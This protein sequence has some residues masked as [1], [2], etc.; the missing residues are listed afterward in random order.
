[1]CCH[2]EV[3]E[4][5]EIISSFP[6]TDVVII[7]VKDKTCSFTVD[8]TKTTAT[9]IAQKLSA[10]GFKSFV[11][12][13]ETIVSDQC[14]DSCST[15]PST[16][17]S[18]ADE[19]GMKAT[20]FAAP[21]LCCIKEEKI[22]TAA[23][24]SLKGIFDID[25]DIPSKTFTVEFTAPATAKQIRDV[26]G[27]QLK[28]VAWVSGDKV[29]EG[30]G[31]CG[32]GGPGHSHGS[33][34]AKSVPIP[35][36]I[37][38]AD[39]LHVYDIHGAL[40]SFVS[41]VPL[42]TLCFESHSLPGDMMTPCFDAEGRSGEADE[43]CMC[44][45]E[46]PHIHAHVKASG[47]GSYN[48]SKLTAV[49]LTLVEGSGSASLPV[50]DALPEDC[51]HESSALIS[52]PEKLSIRV[53]HG[54]HFDD[55]VLHSA[56]TL[57]LRNSHA[58]HGDY[59]GALVKCA[60]RSDVLEFYKIGDEKFNILKYINKKLPS[61]SGYSDPRVMA[62]LNVVP[63]KKAAHTGCCGGGHGNSHEHGHSH[64][65]GADEP[66]SDSDEDADAKNPAST[67]GKSA[68]HVTN[69]CCASEI[70]PIRAIVEPLPGV[71][72]VSFN[73]TS[74]IVYVEHDYSITPLAKI[75]GELNKARFGASV[76]KDA[77]APKLQLNASSEGKSTV[78]V[79]HICCASEIP[80]I[81][82]IVEPLPGVKKVS[83]NVTSKLVYVDH[84]FNVTPVATILEELNKARFGAT[85]R[86]D[87]GAN[88]ASSTATIAPPSVPE[89]THIGGLRWNVVASGILWVVSMFHAAYAPLKYVAIGS[90][91]I[92]IFHIALKCFESLK[93]YTIDSN[94]LM[95]VA[96]VGAMGLQDYPEAAGLTFLFSLGEWLES[97]ATGK[98]RKAL[99]SI[100]NL[101]PETANK[102]ITGPDGA[103]RYKAM[104]AE[105]I[106]IG[107]YV[108]VKS[109]DK[110]P[111]DGTVFKGESVI[112][113]SSLTGES[114]P[115]T[116]KAEDGVYSG[117]INI[118]SS[119]LTVLVTATTENS[120]VAK[121]IELVEEAQ[122]NRSPTEKLVDE[123]AKRYTPIVIV[124]SI[125]MCTI[126]WAFSR[127][128]GVEWT[129]RGVT[130]I[131][132]A[133]PCAL[134]ISTPVTYVAGLAAT[135]QKGI[136]IKGGSHLES[137][138]AVKIVG[139]DKTGTLTHG[140]FQL[141]NLEVV[142]GWEA[143]APKGA[144]KKLLKNLKAR[145]EIM[146]YMAIMEAESSHPM[147]SALVK[148]AK[149]E[150]VILGAQ[151]VAENHKILKGEGV[152][153]TVDG[154]VFY[155]GNVRMIERLGMTSS[156]N[157]ADLTK[158]N[159]W[160]RAGG[161]CGFVAVDGFGVVAMFN[162]AD[163]IRDES[164]TAVADMKKMGIDVYMLTGDGKGAADAVAQ[165]I[166]ID[167][168]FVRSELLPVDKLNYVK[169]FKL[170]D[171][172]KK[173]ESHGLMGKDEEGGYG[174][175]AA[176]HQAQEDDD[177]DAVVS[178][179]SS[180]VEKKLGLFAKRTKVLMC[181]DGVNDA[182]ALA[183]ADVGVAMAAGGA[184]IAM[185]TA[186]IA[187]V[188]SDI[189]KLVFS[190][191]TGRAVVSVI[192]QN[193]VFS[194]VTKLIVITVV[195]MGY[196]SLW[197]AIGS[198][199]GAM[200]IVTLNGMR[201]LPKKDKVEMG[202][203]EE[204]GDGAEEEHGRSHGHGH[205]HSHGHSHGYEQV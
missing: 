44:G 155:V 187:L 154:F 184:A 109:G 83:I 165:E 24:D 166:G 82:A 29:V 148:A 188:D 153:G 46:E 91:F 79:E 30:G 4:V 183:A 121:L 200:L 169:R 15:R 21:S 120:A 89:A 6:T 96:A 181:G 108:L 99:E 42:S 131:V 95:F 65:H 47:C 34:A 193:L 202:M 137:L 106:L 70:P 152:V 130:L 56:D 41:P 117:T 177:E 80:P 204:G 9:K 168:E 11:K 196:G 178:V 62:A 144:N 40:Q 170:M 111:C 10:E 157:G 105:A 18:S 180:E 90:F 26:V 158:S 23:V 20:T 197:L 100:V 67:A 25:V 92:G 185:E 93:R 129:T 52:S 133:C 139:C 53:K 201:L 86:K 33:H 12:A 149:N 74:K 14:N 28:D 143:K 126:P 77:G 179:A 107:D 156:M 122:A 194:L 160:S 195:M 58:G 176:V 127:D 191:Q 19:N 54:D 2:S 73:I 60:E 146:R 186:D 64:G 88:A 128:A 97:R 190:L 174:S 150:G 72:K 124:A 32:G 45:D 66:D 192:K 69:I 140:V 37:I 135:A 94:T 110:V 132:I 13:E 38:T 57:L 55:L 98:A 48:E 118:G 1:M 50:S 76:K 114:R 17:A 7:S 84:D 136:I 125:L 61:V 189:A 16:T 167:P 35:R 138:A 51:H 164:R 31:C 119:P 5:T 102:Q 182:P 68:V 199:I 163:K 27:K 134:I 147:A 151:D 172:T 173:T 175:M 141:L 85:L 203:G 116:K 142:S 75:V 159:I 161:T 171:T 39:V 49:K 78:H 115:V 43:T 112:D 63:G 198:D 101:K 103:I 81:R 162:V 8:N 113:E 59:H 145:K 205:G 87:A 22:I 104:P 3:P 71:T 36:A 123:F